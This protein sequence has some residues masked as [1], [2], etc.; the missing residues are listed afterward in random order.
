MMGLKLTYGQVGQ[1]GL[2]MTSFND[3]MHIG[4]MTLPVSLPSMK[5]TGAPPITAISDA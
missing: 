2:L 5:H 1:R 3:D 4:P